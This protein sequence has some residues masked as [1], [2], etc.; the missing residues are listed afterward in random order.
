MNAALVR[1]QAS[2][3]NI[4]NLN[5]NGFTRQEVSQSSTNGGGT[6][7]TVGTS[8]SGPGNNLATDMVQQLQ[9]Q[10]AF[11]ANLTVF[12]ASNGMLGKLLDTMD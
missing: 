8:V 9:A 6:R 3:H 12:K 11:L 1:F 7:A 4:A 5:T 2:A 10:N